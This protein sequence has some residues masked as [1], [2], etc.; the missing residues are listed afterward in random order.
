MSESV[1]KGVSKLIAKKLKA[2]VPFKLTD[3]QKKV[4]V[5]NLQV[6]S[7]N[8]QPGDMFIA[9]P[10]VQVDG[11]RYANQ[12]VSSGAVCVLAEKAQNAEEQQWLSNLACEL[13]E[14][15]NLQ[16]QIGK[17][18]A[19]FFDQPSSQL[20]MVAITGTNG[21]TSV[22]QLI[23]QAYQTLGQKTAVMGTLGNGVLGDLAS[24]ENTT[25]GPVDVQRL[26]KSFV[27]EKVDLVAM[28]ASSHGLEQSRLTG[29]NIDTAVVTNLSRD[30]LDYHGSMEAY[31]EAKER[32]VTW[33]GLKHLVL[34]ADDESVLAM[35]TKAAKDVA[36]LTFSASGNPA[37]LVATNIVYSHNGVEFD[38][39]YNGKTQRFSS[40]LVGEFNVSNLLAVI[41]VLLI[42]G[43]GLKDLKN[44]IAGLQPI[45]GRMEIVFCRQEAAGQ[46][47]VVVDYAHTPDAL[48]QAIAAVRLHCEGA[49]WC[50]FGCGGDRD[51]GKRALMGEVASQ[52]ADKLVLTNDNP[53]SEKS[54]DIFKAIEEGLEVGTDYI[55]EKD[56]KTAIYDAVQQADAT[57]WVLV[58]GKGHED[59][60]E[61]KGVKHPFNDVKVAKKALKARQQGAAL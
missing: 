44:V 58:A 10:G 47:V 17:L 60:Q 3:T 19:K 22:S 13:I 6:D 7:R 26:L 32:L 29:T 12:A 48:K 2:F 55:V 54:E 43:I 46:P 42:N 33:K 15:E 56:R 37:D 36:R 14:V 39:Q 41:G 27:D 59:Y 38:L 51:Q 28:E 5:S 57:D 30:H 31:Q 53:R 23:A 49:L 52:L 25:P 50:V 1:A 21:K 40:A 9:Y 8:V 61:I 24:T 35:G 16:P 4:E 11:R 18:A 34:N 20:K 45:H